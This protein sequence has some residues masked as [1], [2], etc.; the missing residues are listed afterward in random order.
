M[1]HR[2]KGSV[3][4]DGRRNSPALFRKILC[5]FRV[6]GCWRIVTRRYQSL[7]VAILVNWVTV[8]INFCGFERDE[9]VT[10]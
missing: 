7:D 6:I 9:L 2:P 5:S 10:D 4:N 8:F 1:T 3:P